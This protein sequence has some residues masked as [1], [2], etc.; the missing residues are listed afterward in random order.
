[1]QQYIEF[2]TNHPLLFGMLILVL[3]LLITSEVTRSINGAKSIDISTAISRF[4]QDKATF[5]DIRSNNEFAN[6][7]ITGAINIPET[8]LEKRISDLIKFKEKEI[9]V[10]CQTG[11]RTAKSCKVLKDNGFNTISTLSGGLT[12][13]TNENY[14]IEK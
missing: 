11:I 5:L 2:I 4:N 7:H 1:M 8:D 6:G 3:I 9:I 13:W 10:Y 12:A 14:P